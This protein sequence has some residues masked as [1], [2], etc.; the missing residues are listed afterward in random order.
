MID[1]RLAPDDDPREDSGRRD[2]RGI[3]EDHLRN[4]ASR[5]R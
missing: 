3:L 4:H 1:L 2:E 5:L